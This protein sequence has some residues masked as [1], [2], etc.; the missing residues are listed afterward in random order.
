MLSLGYMCTY[1]WVF[2]R[3]HKHWQRLMVTFHQ[4][5]LV[6][7]P[8]YCSST[9]SCYTLLSITAMLNPTDSLIPWN[10]EGSCYLL[11]VTTVCKVHLCYVF[12]PNPQWGTCLQMSTLMLLWK[13]ADG[14]QPD[15]RYLKMPPSVRVWHQKMQTTPHNPAVYTLFF[16][17]CC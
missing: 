15:T 1:K 12:G 14:S 17:D 3:D 16:T 10:I 13:L 4:L 5:Q 11:Y 6:H 2:C 9:S 8:H 7:S